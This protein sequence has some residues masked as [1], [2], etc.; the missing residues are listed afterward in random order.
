MP[1]NQ[2][3]LIAIAASIATT[4]VLAGL[5]WFLKRRLRLVERLSFPLTVA[6]LV[7]GLK[8]LTMFEAGDMAGLDYV[9]T[10]ALLFVLLILF[11]RVAGLYFFDVHLHAHKGIRLPPLLPPVVMGALYLITALVTLKLA[12]PWWQMTAL[13]AT[14]AVTSLVLGLALQPILGNFFSGIVISLERPFRINDWILFN[15]VEA[16]VVDITWRTTHLRTRDNDNLVIPNSKIADQEIVNFF[17]PHPLHME[18]VYVGVHYRTPPYRV[19]QALMDVAERIDTVLEKPSPSVFLI[20]FG[21]SAITYEL[22]IW[23][24]DF[25]HKPRIVSHVKSEIWEEFRRRDIVIPFP[26]R[27]LEIEPRVN[28]LEVTR[29]ARV[30]TDDDTPALARLFVARGQDR[31]RA[32]H[33]HGQEVTVGRSTSCTLTLL[34]P[35]ASKEHFKI[36][37]DDGAYVLTDLDSHNGTLINGERIESQVLRDFDRIDLGD[38][39]IVF[40]EDDG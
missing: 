27:T 21:D 34:E 28:T 13:V 40:E 1:V 11:L 35:R 25:A 26:I 15:D 31:G 20:D 37:W 33:L 24:E 38:T 22:R 19:K 8:V 23:I 3:L 4:I 32:V 39:V 12:F 6:A 7:G 18:R 36:E 2:H 14:S 29:P 30:D 5:V 17:Y 16:R 10:W 9:L